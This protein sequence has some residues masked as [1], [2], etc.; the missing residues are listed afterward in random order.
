MSGTEFARAKEDVASIMR[1]KQAAGMYTESQREASLLWPRFGTDV[2]VAE[3]KKKE[4]AA[5]K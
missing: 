4:E 1:A 2:V 5:K 3:A